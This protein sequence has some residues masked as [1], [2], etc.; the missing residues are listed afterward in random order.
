MTTT[1]GKLPHPGRR[2]SINKKTLPATLRR[3]HL[4]GLAQPVGPLLDRWRR[5]EFFATVVSPEE[6]RSR[7]VSNAAGGINQPR[8]YH[9]LPSEVLLEVWV[10]FLF[11]SDFA[12]RTPKGDLGGIESGECA[13]NPF[14]QDHPGRPVRMPNTAHTSHV[15]C[16]ITAPHH[17]KRPCDDGPFSDRFR[18]LIPPGRATSYG[19]WASTG[20]VSGSHRWPQAARPNPRNPRSLF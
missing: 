1:S 13:M 19:S 14:I 5:D 15:T 4:L 17:E 20:Q 2:T 10:L 12:G 7:K 9:V 11:L 18:C 8:S 6:T 16:P 3:P